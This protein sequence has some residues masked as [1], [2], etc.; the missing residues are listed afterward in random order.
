[1]EQQFTEYTAWEAEVGG[2]ECTFKGPY[3]SALQTL[4]G[5]HEP[6]GPLANLV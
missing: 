5:M 6:H 3:E 2:K 4:K 1:M